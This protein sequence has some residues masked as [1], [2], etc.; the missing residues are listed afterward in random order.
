MKDPKQILESFRTDIHS[1]NIYSSLLRQFDLE[2]PNSKGNRRKPQRSLGKNMNQ[3]AAALSVCLVTGLSAGIGSAFANS[4]I[5]PVQ[6]P[7]DEAPSKANVNVEKPQAESREPERKLPEHPTDLEKKEEAESRIDDQQEKKQQQTETKDFPPLQNIPQEIEKTTNNEQQERQSEKE[8]EQAGNLKSP[9]NVPA[10]AESGHRKE[11]EQ[12]TRAEYRQQEETVQNSKE[13][14]VTNDKAP[15]EEKQYSP[16]KAAN[17][18]V[19]AAATNEKTAA[20]DGQDNKEQQQIPQTV[21]G[22]VLPDTAGDDLNGV[23]LGGAVAL[24]GSVYTLRKNKV[25][26][27]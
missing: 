16:P 4:E 5:G 9:E 25:E 7:L 23:L 17:K 1:Q 27:S 2:Y 20:N 3:M 6:P 11:L 24:L 21:Q 19:A 15:A 18:G 12:S 8:P 26:S 22:G 10:D 13:S 14:V